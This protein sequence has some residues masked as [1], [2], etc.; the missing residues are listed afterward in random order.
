MSKVLLI[1]VTCGKGSTGKIVTGIYDVL[2][3]HGHECMIAYGRYDAPAGYN[4]YRIGSELDVKIHG[5]LS[6]IT[7]KQGLYSTKATKKFIAK[8]EEFKPDIVHMHNIHGYYLNYKLLFEYLN[9]SGVRVLWTLHDCWSLTGHCTHFEFV[10]C[11]RYKDECGHCMQLKEYPKSLLMDNSK[12][13]K[14]LKYSLFSNMNNMQLITPSAWLK[15]IMLDSFMGK[16][17][18][19]VVPTGIDLDVFKPIDSDLRDKYKLNDKFVILGVANP[20]RERKGLDEFI[21]LSKVLSDK[22]KIVLIGLNDE[23]KKMLPAEILALGKT[24]SI[25]QMA[26]W[27]CCADVYINLTLEDTFPTT[28]IEALACGTPVI[29]YKVGGSAESINEKCGI[30]VDKCDIDAVVLAIKKI[31][32]NEI[33]KE[34]CIKRGAEYDSKLRYEQYYNEVYKPYE[35]AL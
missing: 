7:D 34:D 26:Q 2:K 30:A 6:R 10:G 24:D 13:N 14:K 35:E 8:I 29:T 16:Y 18:I 5:A 11:N 20:W 31:E 15:D 1:N 23:Q 12:A 28:N 19:S 33:A 9:K 27:Y 22:Y 32:N 4:A 25:K 21:K 3:S 17:P